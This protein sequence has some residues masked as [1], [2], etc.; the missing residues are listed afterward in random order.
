MS[1]LRRIHQAFRFEIDPNAAQRTLLARSVGAS[2]FVYNWGLAE[3]L[4]A[5]ELTGQRPLLS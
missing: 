1:D 2:R 3:S 5:Y 4:R